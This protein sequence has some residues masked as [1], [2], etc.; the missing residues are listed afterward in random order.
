MKCLHMPRLLLLEQIFIQLKTKTF[1]VY[2]SGFNTKKQ[3]SHENYDNPVIIN[4][5]DTIQHY[6]LRTTVHKPNAS[7]LHCLD[8]QFALPDQ[9]VVFHARVDATS[10]FHR[11]TKLT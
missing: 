5:L 11:I 8:G 3:I 6:N 1:F 2:T 9:M 7:L 4:H 10:L